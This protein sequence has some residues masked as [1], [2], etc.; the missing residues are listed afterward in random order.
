MSAL[1]LFSNNAIA[2]LAHD[3]GPADM[4]IQVQAGLGS[5]FPQPMLP[6]QFFRITLE[7][8]AAPLSREIVKISGRA[9]DVLLVEAG[10]RG[11]EGTTPSAWAAD[12]TIVDHRVTAAAMTAAL[13][14]PQPVIESLS[15]REPV[16]VM[17]ADT[18]LPSGTPGLPVLVDGVTVGDG[19]RVLFSQ[20]TAAPKNVYIYDQASAQ[21]MEDSNIATAGDAL[22]VQQGTSGGQTQVFNGSVWVQAGQ[23]S[24]DEA[25]Y[26]RAFIGKSST[27]AVL[28]DYSSNNYLA[29]GS[30]LLS[31]MGTL[32]LSLGT[33]QTGH[34]IAATDSVN[35]NLAALD[36]E[37]G[38]A[39][40]T[41]TIISSAATVNANMQS[42]ATELEFLTL[43]STATGVTTEITVDAVTARAVKWLVHCTSQSNTLATYAVEIYALTNGVTSDFTSYAA[44]RTGPAIQGLSVSADLLGGQLRLRVHATDAVDVHARRVSV[45]RAT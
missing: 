24:L 6:G 5:L 45:I 28:P 40:D 11:L 26:M 44:L 2:L 12:H 18:A 4:S 36:S 20:L 10:G 42:L 32:D 16:Q 25:A 41:T 21:F 29:D 7:S 35:H 1:E 43:P 23:S 39:V 33:A 31:A 17:A 27:G 37:I 14:Q 3:L 30:S 34:W 8:T 38:A 9:G 13:E 15:W 19:V 22:Y